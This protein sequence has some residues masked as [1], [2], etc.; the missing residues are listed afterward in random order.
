MQT[1]GISVASTIE[2]ND[3]RI[4]FSK[5]FELLV[6]HLQH[7]VRARVEQLD[8]IGIRKA[9]EHQTFRRQT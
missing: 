7:G 9:S 8:D 3:V 1:L 5:Q 4:A 6:E 2:N